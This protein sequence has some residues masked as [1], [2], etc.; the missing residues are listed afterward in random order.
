M[1]VAQPNG[2]LKL[3]VHPFVRQTGQ[4]KA[5]IHPVLMLDIGRPLS[6][7]ELLEAYRVK[8]HLTYLRSFERGVALYNP[9]ASIDRDVPLHGNYLDPWNMS[10]VPVTSWTLA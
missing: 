8:G 3:G 7:E 5:W 2:S 1:A 6:T 4:I 9:K 10:C